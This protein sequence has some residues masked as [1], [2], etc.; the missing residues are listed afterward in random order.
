[1]QTLLVV[2]DVQSLQRDDRPAGEI[3]AENALAARI[4]VASVTKMY[5]AIY[6]KAMANDDLGPAQRSP[7]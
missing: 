5:V 1:M 4:S 7:G 2:C 6:D 3:Q